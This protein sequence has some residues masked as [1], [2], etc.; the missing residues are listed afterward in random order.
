MGFFNE[1]LAEKLLG[2]DC[3]PSDVLPGREFSYG[4]SPK[5]DWDVK[6][7]YAEKA[8]IPAVPVGWGAGLAFGH[9]GPGEFRE[10]NISFS[11]KKR[12]TVYETGV[13]K[14]VRY[15]PHFYHHYDYPLKEL[16]DFLETHLPN[17]DDPIRYQ[18]LVDEVSYHRS[19]GRM[20]YTNLNG[21]FSG[22]HY[23]LY[24]YENFLMDLIL[25]P[26]EVK[27]IIDGLGEYNL[28]M[29]EHLLKTGLDII[30]FCDDLGSS[31]NLLISP[32]LYRK[33]FRKWHGDLVDLCH[34]YGAFVHMHSHGNINSIIKDLYELGID[35]LNPIDPQEDMNLKELIDKYGD[36]MT[37]VGGINKF[38]F[39]WSPEEQ[40]TY[41]N[42]LF[43][44][45]K[46]GFFLMDSG[47]IPE[48]VGNKEWDY[49]NELRESLKKKYNR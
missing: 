2:N 38:F 44:T 37:F 40:K 5:A 33:Y 17:P 48:N 43:S 12:I 42:K 32:E 24:P 36:R 7:R 19:R 45:V 8:G 34:K 26:D 20:T 15:E 29:A 28:K 3:L 22:V 9:G 11:D 25:K 10:R 27:A 41:L 46:K 31:T 16:A 6:A 13:H 30:C 21:F 23:F 18:G 35:M 47:G 39:N 1:K 14:E 49:F 4:A